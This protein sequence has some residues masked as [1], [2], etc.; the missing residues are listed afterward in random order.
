MTPS[1]AASR[2]DL[3][4]ERGAAL[5]V[6][7][8]GRL[9]EEEDARAVG[10]GEGEVEPAFH[11]ARVAADLAVGRVGEPDPLQQ[12]AAALGALGL[13]EAVQGGLQAHVL[14]AGQQRV[15]GGLLQGGADRRAHLRP[16]GD[17]VVAGDPGGAGGGGEEGGQHQHRRRLAGAVGAEEAVDLALGDLEVDAVDGPGPVLELADEAFDLDAAAAWGLSHSLQAIQ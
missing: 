14:A 3:F 2:G 11:P 16:F 13:A 10:E 7:A 1:S 9:V 5:D 17:D 8:G 4:P 15:E 6:E 12:L